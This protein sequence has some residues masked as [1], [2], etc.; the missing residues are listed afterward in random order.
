[1]R[2]ARN[3]LEL[4]YRCVT[5]NQENRFDAA[6]RIVERSHNFVL[7]RLTILSLNFMIFIISLL[8]DWPESLILIYTIPL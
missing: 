7:S 4:L 5:L 8:L 1:M 6:N 2:D 3:A